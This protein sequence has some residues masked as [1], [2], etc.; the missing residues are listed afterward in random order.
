MV[1]MALDSEALRTDVRMLEEIPPLPQ[2][3]RRLLD[4]LADEEIN[5]EDV[6]R[7]IEEVP[8]LAARIVGLSRSAYFGSSTPA[9]SVSDAIIRV[10]GLRLVRSLAL[11]IV[12]SGDFRVDRCPVFSSEQYWAS[13]LLA[14]GMS[15]HLA[16]STTGDA[17][18]HPETA[19]LC[20]VLHNIGL[21]ALVH[22][23]PQRMVSVLEA[24]THEPERPLTAIETEHLG[25][26][27]CE[28]GAWLTTRWHLPSEVEAAIGRH[29]DPEF[30]GPHWGYALV[31]GIS[32]RWSRQRLAGVAE[33][34]VQPESLRALGVSTE[35]F[36]S[37]A[38]R[39]E[40]NLDEIGDLGKLLAGS[41]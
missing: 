7:V 41:S 32:T 36:E 19:Y 21:L 10:L 31:V 29:H 14:A 6:A 35:S 8:P 4:V 15:R 34:W 22:V 18:L 11:G 37:C 25:V 40:N 33:P 23:D 39:C 5:L 16:C 13:A 1:S 2:N 27:H 24:A 26:H 3:T 9:R 28:V 17:A 30:R 38:T 12:L 20:G